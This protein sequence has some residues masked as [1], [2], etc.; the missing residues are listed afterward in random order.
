[1]T[2]DMGVEMGCPLGTGSLTGEAKGIVTVSPFF[3]VS[4]SFPLTLPSQQ[5]HT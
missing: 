4:A 1:V 3:T 2:K 5:I